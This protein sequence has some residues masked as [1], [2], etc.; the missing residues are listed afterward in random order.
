MIATQNIE[1][2]DGNC[3]SESLYCMYLLQSNF[4]KFVKPTAQKRN[5]Q[6][7]PHKI[8]SNSVHTFFRFK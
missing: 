6:K 4:E 5:Q 2:L 1:R 8:Y 7:F 3:V